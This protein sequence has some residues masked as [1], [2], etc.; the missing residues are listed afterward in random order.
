MTALTERLRSGREA[1]AQRRRGAEDDQLGE[2]R[3]WLRLESQAFA[4]Y[5]ESLDWF[6][7][8]DPGTREAREEWRAAMSLIPQLPPAGAF[9]RE[10]GE[11]PYESLL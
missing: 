10:R 4:H 7:A 1:A 2:Y 11:E 3:A 5:R 6:G 9:A 8:D